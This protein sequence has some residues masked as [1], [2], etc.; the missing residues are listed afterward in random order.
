[1][2]CQDDI[3]RQNKYFCN[4]TESF[5]LRLPYSIGT[6]ST[7]LQDSDLFSIASRTD[8]LRLS[9]G[10]IQL[11]LGC[12]SRNF[13]TWKNFLSV[14]SFPWYYVLYHPLLLHWLHCHPCK[15]RMISGGDRYFSLLSSAFFCSVS[16]AVHGLLLSHIS[17]R[18]NEDSLNGA[19]GD[20]LHTHYFSSVT[21][22]C[23]IIGQNMLRMPNVYQC[24]LFINI[25]TI[26]GKSVFILYIS[27]FTAV[28]SKHILILR[29]SVDF[30]HSQPFAMSR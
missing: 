25:F 13:Q 22:W 5:M 21:S 9:L 16:T 30:S 17:I 6:P 12:L 1:M 14:Q 2:G 3:S 18:K 8:R 19:F 7:W 10:V 26:S 20:V 4:F 23:V 11:S 27:L 29:Y 24:F 28:Q 15:C